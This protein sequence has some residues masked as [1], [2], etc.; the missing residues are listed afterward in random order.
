MNDLNSLLRKVKKYINILKKRFINYVRTNVMVMVFIITNLINTIII[1]GL[2]VGNYLSLKPVLAD[3]SIL[4]L[5]SAFAYFIKP[6]RQIIYLFIWS[7]AI[8]LMCIINTIYYSNYILNFCI[9]F[10]V[11]FTFFK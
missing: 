9:F 5:I 2:T 8:T 11:N 7:S 4:L 10:F 3:L 1:R 6:K